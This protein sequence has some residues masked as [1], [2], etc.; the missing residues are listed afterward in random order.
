MESKQ[1]NSLQCAESGATL[2]SHPPPIRGSKSPLLP[3][4]PLAWGLTACSVVAY[5][6]VLGASACPVQS[7]LQVSLGSP[8]LPQAHVL[9]SSCHAGC[10]D[11]L[12]PRGLISP[13]GQPGGLGGGVVPTADPLRQAPS[14][15]FPPFS[16][17]PDPQPGLLASP[18]PRPPLRYPPQPLGGCPVPASACVNV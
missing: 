12:P 15:P 5:G 13:L 11:V 14:S 18:P 8:P 9:C 4:P 2:G 6:L 7:G 10:L 16:L 3:S 17:L 1:N